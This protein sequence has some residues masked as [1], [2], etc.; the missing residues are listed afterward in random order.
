[1]W[2]RSLGLRF[3]IFGVRGAR[4]P[5]PGG[6]FHLDPA[7]LRGGQCWK[8]AHEGGGGCSPRRG[9]RQRK[10]MLRVLGPASCPGVGRQAPPETSSKAALLYLPLW[11]SL[12][13]QRKKSEE[14][15]GLERQG[16]QEG[17][18]AQRTQS[19]CKCPR[20]TP[21]HDPILPAFS[22][23]PVPVLLIPPQKG[24]LIPQPRAPRDV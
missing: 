7:R 9:C 24:P 18:C 22:S 14:S 1:M 13:E 5:R 16:T 15:D 23:T 3:P 20:Q 19:R 8:G 12:S 4:Y 17:G 21:G 11:E 2:R 10:W 6:W